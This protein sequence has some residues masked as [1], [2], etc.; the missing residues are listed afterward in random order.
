[1]EI[2]VIG[3][4]RLGSDVARRLMRGGHRVV[5]FD[6]DRARVDALAAEGAT[7]AESIANAVARLAAPRAVWVAVHTGEPTRAILRELHGRLAAGDVVMDGG[8]NDW[9]EDEERA[10]EF[11]KE[12]VSYLDVGVA[13]GIHG[14]SE[15]Y[16]LMVGGD[17]AAVD[18]LKHAFDALAAPQGF[19]YV[20]PSGA[21]HY[22][23]MVHAAIEYGMMESLAEGF[24]LLRGAPHSFDLPQLAGLWRHGSVIRSWLLDLT[25]AT[26]KKDAKLEGDAGRVADTGEGRWAVETAIAQESPCTLLAAS[27]FARFRSRH[28]DGYAVRLRGALHREIGGTPAGA[29]AP[30][31][32]APA[33]KPEPPTGPPPK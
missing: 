30:L 33:A 31:A 10:A 19:A 24:E 20:G 21:G 13:G 7:G 22:A 11:A 8:S 17:K 32:G 5:G 25:Y 6:P 28:E 14:I 2:A 9:R 3:L 23:K 26:L 18:R 29:G 4:G 27:Y 12:G 1:M 16:C 15:G